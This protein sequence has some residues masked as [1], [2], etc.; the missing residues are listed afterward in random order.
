MDQRVAEVS[1]AVESLHV[2]LAYSLLETLDGPQL[3]SL[4]LAVGTATPAAQFIRGILK[5]YDGD[6]DAAV[7]QLNGVLR[8]K[9]SPSVGPFVADALASV[10]IMRERYE[11]VQSLLRCGAFAGE[12]LLAMSVQCMIDARVSSN[13]E[14]RHTL[15]TAQRL[16]HEEEDDIKRA[17][18]LARLAYAAYYIEEFD[19]A[20]N[21]AA[22]CVRSAEPLGAQR[23]AA[24]AL[25]ITY[26]IH[27]NVKADITDARYYALR[28]YEAAKRCSNSSF[29][30]GSLVALYECA[31]LT[32]DDAEATRLRS[33]IK[34][35]ELPTQY[36]EAFALRL[37]DALA[38]ARQDIA[39]T[40]T[41]FDLLRRVST[42]S[43]AEWAMCTA[44][45]ALASA[46]TGD[47][48]A[49]RSESRRAITKLGR[50]A[51]HQPG[52]ERRYRRIA[53]VAAAFTCKLIGDYVR[54]ERLEKSAELQSRPEL[55]LLELDDEARKQSS[56]P[57]LRTMADIFQSAASM[58]RKSAP[59][60]LLTKAERDVL[61]LFAEGMSA[62]D[63]ARET[64]RSVH[65][66]YNH[67]RSLCS[68]LGARR[69]AEAV[70]KARRSKLI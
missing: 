29:M 5:L 48:D 41:Q 17:R 39:N 22:S 50:L 68:K 23:I 64:A 56:D 32:G 55:Q 10:Y 51:R 25:S 59:P 7:Q 4:R 11:D 12:R 63:I 58:R 47:D 1:A 8:R 62:G 38:A 65:T 3:H 42:R 31:V 61:R 15:H 16:L 20:F 36:L 35:R 46:A 69:S 26:N 28:C 52:Y 30:Y 44:L 18:V 67:S 54:A 66:I 14:A 13:S 45:L 34:Q 40:C 21:M 27:M 60:T 49:A 19:E 43:D 6:V 33:M 9:A 70:A 37:S 57:A 24:A 53:R 2:G